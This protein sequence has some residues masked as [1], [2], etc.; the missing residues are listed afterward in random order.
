MLSRFSNIYRILSLF[1]KHQGTKLP[2]VP[3]SLI[4]NFKEHN[5]PITVVT[6]SVAR[7]RDLI[8][9]ALTRCISSSCSVIVLPV[10]LALANKYFTCVSL[11]SFN[12]LAGLGTKISLYTLLALQMVLYI[13]FLLFCHSSS[14]SMLFFYILFALLSAVVPYWSQSWRSQR[15]F[16]PSLHFPL[17]K[18]SQLLCSFSGTFCYFVQKPSIARFSSWQQT[19]TTPW[20][21]FGNT[22]GKRK[23]TYNRKSSCS[24]DCS[25]TKDGPALK[26]SLKSVGFLCM[27]G[28]RR[29]SF[30]ADTNVGEDVPQTGFVKHS[31][32]KII[33]PALSRRRLPNNFTCLVYNQ[34]WFQRCWKQANCRADGN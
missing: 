31:V 9:A 22:K 6:P 21:F 3:A 26:G 29:F 32:L 1:T 27:C 23:W 28:C 20:S 7:F 33:L 11:V 10:F 4:Y 18:H 16:Q 19:W 15:G 24:Q 5:K 34:D 25:F 14:L 8:L 2:D 12:F 30:P 13:F 17:N